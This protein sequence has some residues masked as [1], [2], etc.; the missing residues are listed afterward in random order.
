ML[1]AS[2]FRRGQRVELDGD[3]Y[4]ILDVRFQSPSAR[5]A[6]TL[7]KA[8][9]RNLRTGNVFDRTFRAADKVAEPQLELRAVQYL[10]SDG[11]AYHFM[12][13]ASYEQFALSAADLGDDALY[14]IAGLSGIRS[15]IF[16]GRVMSIELPQTIVL[17]IRDTDPA[18][19]GA[20]AQA[21]TK[22][23]TLETGLVIQIPSYLEPG[24]AV[25]VD[26]RDARFIGRAKS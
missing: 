13:S 6:S 8:K 20:T 7:V 21:Q 11:D 1:S 2:E 18:L 10:Y 26:T 3:P 16:N 19:K 9:V 15:V 5:G 14:L 24:E 12:D 22:P 17:R 23:A 4:V 25:Q